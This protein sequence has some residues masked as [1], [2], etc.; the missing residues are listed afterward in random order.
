MNDIE[1]KPAYSESKTTTVGVFVF[2][3]SLFTFGKLASSDVSEMVT[4]IGAIITGVTGLIQALG[5][6]V[7]VFKS[8]W[9]KK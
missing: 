2:L 6:L 4:N 9:H 5:G 8:V 3:S 7:L 1:T